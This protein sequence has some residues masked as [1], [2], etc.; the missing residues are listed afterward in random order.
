MKQSILKCSAVRIPKQNQLIL[1]LNKLII[2]KYIMEIDDF[3]C[4]SCNSVF[5]DTNRSPR[6]LTSCGHTVCQE[7]LTSMLV[8]N[9]V[10]KCPEDNNEYSYTSIDELPKNVILI[11]LLEKT[12]NRRS[13]FSYMN[14]NMVNCTP[15]SLDT[16][17]LNFSFTSSH[18][19]NTIDVYQSNDMCPFTTSSMTCKNNNNNFRSSFPHVQE[20]NLDTPSIQTLQNQC[21]KHKRPLEIVCLDHRTKACTSCALFGEHKNHNLRSEED[22]M[23]EVSLKAEI[24]IEFYELI[25]KNSEKYDTH[26]NKEMKLL[27]DTKMKCEDTKEKLKEKVSNFFKELRFLLKTKEEQI[28]DDIEEKYETLINKKIN[29]LETYPIEVQTRVKDWKKEYYIFNYLVYRHV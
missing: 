1:V 7:C 21:S 15:L 23:K 6:L 19:L 14:N 13:T 12:R 11:K 18:K 8:K 24:L 26:I 17:A 3:N 25:D 27:K 10:I 4:L 29:Y 22:I 2:I 9:N 28:N 16:S 5:N 20:F